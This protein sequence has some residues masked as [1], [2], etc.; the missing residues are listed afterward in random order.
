MATIEVNS[1]RDSRDL[2]ANLITE[3]ICHD[4]D[5]SAIMDAVILSKKVIDSERISSMKKEK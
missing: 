4:L 5:M 2:I 1:K 3:M